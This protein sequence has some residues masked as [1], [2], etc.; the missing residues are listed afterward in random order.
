MRQACCQTVIVPFNQNRNHHQQQ[1]EQ[2]C[3]EVFNEQQ[4]P[5]RRG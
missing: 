1:Q 3:H 4:T 5:L 2:Q